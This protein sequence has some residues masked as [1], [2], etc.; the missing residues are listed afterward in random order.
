MIYLC[1]STKIMTGGY[2]MFDNNI[3]ELAKRVG[4]ITVEDMCQYTIAE[5]VYKIANKM[6][7]LLNEVGTFESDVLKTVKEQND[8]IHYL[9]GEGLHLEVATIFDQWMVDGTFDT[10]I[11]QTALKKLNERIDETHIINSPIMTKEIKAVGEGI[12]I[13]ITGLQL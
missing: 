1:K 9:L 10:L 4:L 2:K 6:N 5:L 12:N 8:K 13:H 7:E 3:H 11:N